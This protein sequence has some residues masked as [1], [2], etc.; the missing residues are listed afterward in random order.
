MKFRLLIASVL[1]A[2]AG[3]VSAA[4][5]E[6]AS[7]VVT[8][9]NSDKRTITIRNADTGKRRTYFLDEGTRISSEGNAIALNRIR[10][11]NEVSLRYRATDRG[12]VIETVRLPELSEIVDVI[13]VEITEVQTVSGRITGVRPSL[14]TITIRDDATRQ[15]RTLKI[16]E[17]VSIT[18][19]GEPL[20]LRNIERGDNI[21]ARYRVTDRGLIL[22][23]GR[24]PQP[25]AQPATE[26]PAALPK[27]A[28]HVFAYLFAALSLFGLGAG[29]RYLRRRRG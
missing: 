16:P 12:R 21:S 26:A 20:M 18:R 19:D 13:P 10:K 3:G 9:V 29:A 6:T 15:R 2:F 11:G 24:A 25:S 17:G 7:G 27:T 1:L 23:T 28:G 8:N 14:R 5:A 4:E 22:V